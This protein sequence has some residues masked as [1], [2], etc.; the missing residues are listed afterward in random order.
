MQNIAGIVSGIALQLQGTS[1][2]CASTIAEKNNE[3]LFMLARGV[4]LLQ[5]L[6]SK[7]AEMEK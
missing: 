5:M 3:Q 7:R 2:T 6:P 1:S 4:D